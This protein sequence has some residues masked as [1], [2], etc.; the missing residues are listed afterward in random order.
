VGDWY[1]ELLP[2]GETFPAKKKRKRRSARAWITRIVVVVGFVLFVFGVYSAVNRG[3]EWL[4]ARSAE[5]TSTTAVASVKVTIPAGMTVSQIGQLLEEKGVV[6]SAA[7]FVDVVASRG[8]EQKLQAG[9]YQLPTKAQLVTIVAKLEQGRAVAKTFDVTIPEGLAVGQVAALLA[10]DGKVKQPATYKDLSTQPDEFVVPKVGGAVPQGLTTLEGLLFPDTY[11]LMTGDGPTELIG[12]QLSA[13]GRKTSSLPWDNAEGLGLSP[14]QIVIVASMLEKEANTPEDMAKVAA[15]IY[16][17]LKKKM[18]LQ[19]DAT[20]RYAL[21]KWTEPLT[22]EDL[23]VNSPYNT[24]VKKGLPPAPIASPGI[25][26]LTAALEPAAVDYLYYLTDKDGVTHF[27][28][29]ADEFAKLKK[30]VGQ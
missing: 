7:A 23:K 8:S 27:T 14:Y 28:A 15:V 16:N 22:A 21:D 30:N 10:K 13:F 26:A 20:V 19:I 1:S 11:E 5:T 4:Q 12:A 17:R 3:H 6:S 9:T 24:R 2:A 29:S 25:V 18:A